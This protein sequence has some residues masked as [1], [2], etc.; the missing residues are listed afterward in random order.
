MVEKCGIKHGFSD[1][2][3]IREKGHSGHCWSKAERGTGGTVTYFEWLSRGGKFYT[4]VGYQT[5]YPM[6]ASR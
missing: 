4:H 1:A 6:N 5:I 2:K 3:C